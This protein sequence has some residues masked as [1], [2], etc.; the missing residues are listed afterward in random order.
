M[1]LQYFII[2]VQNI[3]IFLTASARYN[4]VKQHSTIL[5]LIMCF[6]TYFYLNHLG[7][8]PVILEYSHFIEKHFEI[9][10]FYCKNLLQ[11]L[12]LFDLHNHDFV[13]MATGQTIT[14]TDKQKNLRPSHYRMSYPLTTRSYLSTLNCY[15]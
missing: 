5:S 1:K 14:L 7:F 4:Y 12:K 15:R 10:F 2:S 3:D 13:T 9:T 6:D 11:I 8:R